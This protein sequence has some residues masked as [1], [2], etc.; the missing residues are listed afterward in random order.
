[1]KQLPILVLKGC[2]CVGVPLCSMHVPTSFDGR[3]GSELSTSHIFLQCVLAVITLAWGEFGDGVARAR[4]RCELGLVLCSVAISTLFGVG[5]GTKVLKQ[6]PW[7]PDLSQFH[8]KYVLSPLLAMAP[9]TQRGHILLNKILKRIFSWDS[10][11][12]S[13]TDIS[14]HHNCSVKNLGKHM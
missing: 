3:A 10:Y 5:L 13:Y 6:K 7:V 2:P 4:A 8:S 1:M 9:L 11:E 12:L 14:L